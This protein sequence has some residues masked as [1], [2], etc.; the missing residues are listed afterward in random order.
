MSTLE[1]R[2]L[3]ARVC[4][5]IT[6]DELIALAARFR[7]AQA[8]VRQASAYTTYL[9]DHPRRRADI[10]KAA[11]LEDQARTEMWV[12]WVELLAECKRLDAEITQ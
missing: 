7:Q 3:V 8:A 1:D 10:L 6:T 9:F 12:V 11:T 4:A 5:T 2:D